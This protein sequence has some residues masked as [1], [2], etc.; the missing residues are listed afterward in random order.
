MKIINVN[1]LQQYLLHHEQIDSDHIGLMSVFNS[2][3]M[4]IKNNDIPSFKRE[5]NSLVY[6]AVEH[7]SREEQLMIESDYP[8]Y[9]AHRNIHEEILKSLELMTGLDKLNSIHAKKF[10]TYFISHI[11]TVDRAFVEYLEQHE[12]LNDA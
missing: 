11:D 10:A 4:A 7:F 3:L 8:N 6:L 1:D 9:I 5:L 12:Q 2:I